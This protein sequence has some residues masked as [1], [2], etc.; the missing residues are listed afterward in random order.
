MPTDPPVASPNP[1]DDA[2]GVAAVDYSA[3]FDSLSKRIENIE[4][5]YKYGTAPGNLIRYIPGLA[6]P[7]CGGQITNTIEKKAYPEDLYRDQKI[8]TFNIQLAANQYM[9][10]HDV[11][12]VFP[13]RIK[14]STNNAQNI[15][16]DEI[17]VNNFLAHWIK[18]IDIKRYGDDT[19]ILPLTN[20]VEIY[21]YSDAMLKHIPKNALEV[22]RYD[23]LYSKKKV[24]I[25]ANNE[26][27]RAHRT[28]AKG[29][30][31]HR[32]DDN[33][34]DRIEKFSDQL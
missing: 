28:N 2:E 15:D 18:E 1:L 17:T 24:K 19:P 21:K 13:M 23:L 6:K 11:H 20:N 7:I 10:F 26:D 32:T 27:R 25:Q 30:A 4:K 31:D 3:D 29:N 5:L 9:N 34:D 8:A 14:R 33:L 22:L 16:D 12:L